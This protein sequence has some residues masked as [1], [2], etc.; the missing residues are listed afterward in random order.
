MNSTQYKNLNFH[1]GLHHYGCVF[2]KFYYDNHSKL[3]LKIVYTFKQFYD[4]L[5]DGLHSS[6]KIN[7]KEYFYSSHLYSS[8]S[9]FNLCSSWN[10]E[11][12]DGVYVFKIQYLNLYMPSGNCSCSYT[13][14]NANYKLHYIITDRISKYPFEHNFIR[15][16]QFEKFVKEENFKEL[17]TLIGYPMNF[18]IHRGVRQDCPST[19][20]HVLALLSFMF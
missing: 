18:P 6:V 17:A 8:S 12:R 3:N 1:C 20:V 2:N 13:A 14:E 19:F 11:K 10:S 7:Y 15:S 9:F 5:N 16:K 4:L